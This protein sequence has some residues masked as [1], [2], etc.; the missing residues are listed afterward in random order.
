MA[1]KTD[2]LAAMRAQFEALGY[3]GDKMINLMRDPAWRAA[4][5]AA[6]APADI[7]PPPDRGPLMPDAPDDWTPERERAIRE[8]CEAAPEGPWGVFE[9]DCLC[10]ITGPTRIIGDEGEMS[11][12]V[13][14][15]I[16][17]A[18][19]DLPAALREIERLRAESTAMRTAAR[20]VLDEWSDGDPTCL[21]REAIADL[22]DAI[23][24]A[25]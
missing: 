19:T 18:R 7:R 6:G 15:F 1:D 12:S 20:R 23:K 10:W 25:P 14:A 16:A 13:A 21:S 4:F 3:D 22:Q 24:G 5:N 8:R 11:R 2:P 9:Q 17:H